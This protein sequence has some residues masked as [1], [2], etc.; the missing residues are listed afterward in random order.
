MKYL[1]LSL[2]FIPS[3]TF[4]QSVSVAEPFTG[5]TPASGLN[6]DNGGTGW[7]GAWSANSA[8]TTDVDPINSGNIVGVWD[9]STG[10]DASRTFTI[11]G[12]D[13]IYAYKFRESAVPSASNYGYFAI[14]KQASTNI[15]CFEQG[16]EF[17]KDEFG[18]SDCSG[19]HQQ[20]VMTGVTNDHWYTIEIEIDQTNQQVRARVDGGTWSPWDSIS[21]VQVDTVR[22]TTL[23]GTAITYYVDDIASS[24]PGGGGGGTTSTTTIYTVD[25][26]TQDLFNGFILFLLTAGG[27]I[28]FFRKR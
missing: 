16:G 5:Y 10:G 14:F 3:I 20:S 15:F 13:A 18:I 24:A 9:A 17:A 25:N 7:A 11:D 19:G 8:V 6:G 27:V 12:T 21:F 28:W 2:L 22:Y 26:P 23:D 1:F 4:A